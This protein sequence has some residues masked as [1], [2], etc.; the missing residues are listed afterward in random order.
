MINLDKSYIF[1]KTLH[2]KF[3]ILLLIFLKV[4]TI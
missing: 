1:G 3:S 4:L 2:G